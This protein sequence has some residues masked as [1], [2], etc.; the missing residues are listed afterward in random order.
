MSEITPTSTPSDAGVTPV[1]ELASAFGAKSDQPQDQAQ[2]QEH[3]D[4]ELGTSQQSASSSE[5]TPDSSN[6]STPSR[7]EIMAGLTL[8][9]LRAH[10]TLGPQLQSY[11]QSEAASQLKGKTESIRKELQKEAASKQFAQLSKE[12]LGELLANDDEAAAMYAELKASPP[13]N[14]NQ[15]ADSAAQTVSYFTSAIRTHSSKV[16]AS[17]L[18]AET[19]AELAP[20]KNLNAA[21]HPGKTAEQILAAWQLKIDNALTDH[22]VK[23]ATKGLSE[24]LDLDRQAREDEAKAGGGGALMSNGTHAAP[25]PDLIKTPGTSLLADAF[26][27]QPSRSK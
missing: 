10:P 26:Q 11:A 12:E 7:E 14:P 15:P 25:L 27:R 18:P 21:D 1:A 19:K 23:S 2:Q 22:R 24:S 20:E 5:R 17:D 13:P 9:E 4:E 6:P 8:E 3:K 16:D